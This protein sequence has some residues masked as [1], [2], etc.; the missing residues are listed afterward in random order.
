MEAAT[1][2]EYETEETYVYVDFDSKLLDEQLSDADT[3]IKFLG[4]H[5]AQPIMQLNNQLFKGMRDRYKEKNNFLQSA[6]CEGF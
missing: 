4:M 5:T 1:D 2:D 3:K 6:L